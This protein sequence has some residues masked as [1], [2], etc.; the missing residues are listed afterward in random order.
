MGNGAIGVPVGPTNAEINQLPIQSPASVYDL[1]NANVA[2]APQPSPPPA[3]TPDQS[4][5]DLE[6][7]SLQTFQNPP[8]YQP[9][10]SQFQQS[11]FEQPQFRPAPQHDLTPLIQQQAAAM[12]IPTPRIPRPT[13]R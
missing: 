8:T 11:Q 3:M 7:R 2:L 6:Q 9:G 1:R 4:T 13:K 12:Q 5:A 10:V